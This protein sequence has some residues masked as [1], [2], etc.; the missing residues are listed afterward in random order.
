MYRG[1]KRESNSIRKYPHILPLFEKFIKNHNPSFEF[2][3]VYVNRN[4]I[5]KKHF[6]SKNSGDSLIVGF[7]SY[8]GGRTILYEGDTVKKI[9]I[10]SSSLIFDGSKILHESTMF[11]GTRYSLVFFK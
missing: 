8:T 11:K 9:H 5:C 3:S 7:G 6:D 1:K 10:K 4:V 2:K